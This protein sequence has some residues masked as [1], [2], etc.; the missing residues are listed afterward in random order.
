MKRSAAVTAVATAIAVAS[1][2]ACLAADPVD[3]LPEAMFATGNGC[4]VIKKTLPENVETF[5]FHAFYNTDLYGP[6]L[7]CNFTDAT[8]A[9]VKSGTL[10][11]VKANCQFGAATKPSTIVIRQDAAKEGVQVSMTNAQG[12]RV[13]LGAFAHCG[14]S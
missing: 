5:T 12:K 9:A 3:V 6:D 11:T 8:E 4:A 2:G 1:A 7:V 10:W 14:R 13:D